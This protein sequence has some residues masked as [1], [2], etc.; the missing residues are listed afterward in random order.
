M[1]KLDGEM[2]KALADRVDSLAKRFDALCARRDAN[3]S[4]EWTQG[5]VA[6]GRGKE[7]SACPYTSDPQKRDWLEGW[8]KGYAEEFNLPPM[9]AAG[10]SRKWEKRGKTWI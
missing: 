10:S 8:A 6:Q 1:L 5:Y 9:S 3:S 4:P 7:K 2:C